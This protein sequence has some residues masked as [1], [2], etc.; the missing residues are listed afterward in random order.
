[1]DRFF[2]GTHWAPNIALRVM[3]LRLMK[4]SAGRPVPTI[5][6]MAG[7]LLIALIAML[8]AVPVGLFAAI[9]MAEFAPQRVRLRQADA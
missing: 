2:F 9:Y 3:R 6:V 8:V 4:M 1:M 5:P 7:T